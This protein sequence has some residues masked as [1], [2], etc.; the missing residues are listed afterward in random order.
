[1]QLDHFCSHWLI[2]LPLKFFAPIMR[3]RPFTNILK[4]VHYFHCLFWC[5]QGQ[6]VPR[7]T[8]WQWWLQQSWRPRVQ[9]KP[10]HAR[11]SAMQVFLGERI[12]SRRRL[13]RIRSHTEKLIPKKHH[14]H[15]L[16]AILYLPNCVF[17]LFVLHFQCL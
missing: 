7:W 3:Y 2:K 1:M 16:H 13:L 14:C 11:W 12:L 10:A 8:T 17:Y 9:T 5:L 15:I 4:F 6:P